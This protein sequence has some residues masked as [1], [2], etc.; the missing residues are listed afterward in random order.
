[1]CVYNNYRACIYS[2]EFM[3][4]NLHFDRLINL[5]KTSFT[6]RGKQE[7]NFIYFGN[8]ESYCTFNK[9]CIIP[10]YFP[11]NAACFV[12]LSFSVRLI[13]MFIINCDPNMQTTT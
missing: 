13:C 12:I 9:C 8:K 1:M 6:I 2:T 5:L 3:Q 10:V 7:I 11:Q 4:I